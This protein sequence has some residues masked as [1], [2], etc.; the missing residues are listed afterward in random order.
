[1][2]RFLVLFSCFLVVF[3]FSSS[4]YAQ[5]SGVT[6][7]SYF[8]KL[9]EFKKFL[10]G[11]SKS[12]PVRPY[13]RGGKIPQN[14]QWDNKDWQPEYWVNDK[15]SVDAVM[16]GLYEE[17]VLVRGYDAE[18]SSVHVG[19]SFMRLSPLEQRKV[20]AFID[21]AYQMTDSDPNAGY[22]LVLDGRKKQAIGVY[23]R[24]GLQMQ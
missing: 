17:N 6:E 22:Q 14:V 18:D 11:A 1:M 23:T 5:D 19:Q 3:G 2:R 12:D 21:Y 20:A 24:L 15:G 8:Q 10:P 4:V 16:T 9:M 13:V 7:K